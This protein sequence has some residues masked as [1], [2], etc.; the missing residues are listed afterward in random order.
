MLL[1]FS[2]LLLLLTAS[3]VPVLAKGSAMAINPSNFVKGINNPFMPLAPGTTFTYKGV[4]ADGNEV[5]MVRVTPQTKDILG[6]T[7]EVVTDKV[8]TNNVL[9]ES[10]IDWFAQDKKGNVWYF[11]E[12]SKTLDANGNV[13]STEGSWMGG[14]N[15]AQ[16]G[17]VMEAHPKVG[18]TYR[19]EFS[20]GVAEDMAKVVSLNASKTVPFGS[21]K[22]GLLKTREWTALE[23]GFFEFK[24]YARGVGNIFTISGDKTEWS[25]LVK[26][27]H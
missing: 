1:F 15:N 20:A 10:T 22:S 9:T 16:P 14:V 24:Y 12:D 8:Y 2:A 17:I 21:F 11:G 3:I 18:D 26:V 5:N 27:E 25:A 6:V 7:C 19:Q 4:N 23:P 13:V